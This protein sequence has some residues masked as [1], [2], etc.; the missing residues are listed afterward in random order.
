[1]EDNLIN[2][3]I[4]S[5]HDNDMIQD[6]SF[7]YAGYQVVRG[8]FFDHI[9]EPS[10]TFNKCKISANTACVNKLTEVDYV[11]ILV[12]PNEMKLAIRPCKEDEKDSF[13]WCG[14]NQKNRSKKAQGNHMQIVFL[15]KWYN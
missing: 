1:M 7:N 2:R 4:P 8:E 15:Q 10:I 11:Q 9:N 13:L 12:N 5:I 6:E 3:S 14:I